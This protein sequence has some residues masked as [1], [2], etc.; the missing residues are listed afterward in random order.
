MLIPTGIGMG[1]ERMTEPNDIFEYFVLL[2]L[3]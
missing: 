3:F 2:T 1:I